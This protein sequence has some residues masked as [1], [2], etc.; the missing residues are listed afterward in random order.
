RCPVRFSDQVV[1]LPARAR[2]ALGAPAG[3]KLSLIPFE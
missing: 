2:E 3:A 1:H